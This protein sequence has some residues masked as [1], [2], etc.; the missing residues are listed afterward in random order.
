MHFIQ[1]QYNIFFIVICI[2]HS[3]I[4]NTFLEA[5]HEKVSIFSRNPLLVN[6]DP[7]HQLPASLFVHTFIL[8]N[9]HQ[10]FLHH[11]FSNCKKVNFII[12]CLFI[13]I[14]YFN[15]SIPILNFKPQQYIHFTEMPSIQHH[16]Q[17]SF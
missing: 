16:E 3:F 2:L 6:G 17:S 4:L 15:K 7:P 11:I 13:Y 9:H 10:P 8:A 12:N 14:Y 5:I 1:P